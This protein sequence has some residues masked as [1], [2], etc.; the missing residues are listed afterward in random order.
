MSI[1]GQPVQRLRLEYTKGE[2]L[3]YASHL[4]MM[5]VW[6]RAFRRAGLPIAHTQG[7]N[8]RPRIGMVCPLPTGVTSR[9]E[10]LDVFLT[11]ELDAGEVLRKL[12]GTLPAGVDVLSVHEV[13]LGLPALMAL[14]AVVEYQSRVRWS[15]TSESLEA[16]L[17]EWMA[18]Q[19]VLRERT[20][21][22][23]KDTYDLRP[24]VESLWLVG[25]L[26]EE[27]VLGMRLRS[28]PNGTGRPDEMLKALGLWEDARG[29]ERSALLLPK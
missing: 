4:D 7:F 25:R 26:G 11:E 21:K 22:D 13:S 6:E 16:M 15:G 10:L 24:L 18:Q 27:W 19:S 3:R 14:T 17:Q 9:A 8:P 1:G 12:N 20:R 28:G 23:R 5:R 2:P 29:V